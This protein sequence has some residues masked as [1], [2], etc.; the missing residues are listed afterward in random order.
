[1]VKI[2]HIKFHFPTAGPSNCLA[3]GSEL[4][5]YTTEEEATSSNLAETLVGEGRSAVCFH[6]WNPDHE[7][8]DYEGR[9]PNLHSVSKS[10]LLATFTLVW[11][12]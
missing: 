11:C 7:S 6:S 8:E 2:M 4:I 3:S 12:R 10:T 5:C 9:T 1:M